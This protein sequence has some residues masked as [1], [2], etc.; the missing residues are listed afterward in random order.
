MH[1]KPL[2]QALQPHFDSLDPRRLDFIA[3]FIIALLHA[4][5]V[6]LNKLGRALGPYQISSNARR[7]KRFLNFNFAPELIARF[8]LAFIKDELLVL[9]M[10]RFSPLTSAPDGLGA[11]QLE[12]RLAQLE[13]S[14]HRHRLPRHCLTD[15]LGQLG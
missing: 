12:I 15:C 9:R 7:I 8:V 1:H 11:H 10:D 2:Q 4:Q 5:T 6:N 13:F 3:R 14:R